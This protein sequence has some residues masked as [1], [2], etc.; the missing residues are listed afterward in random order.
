MLSVIPSQR[1]RARRPVMSLSVELQPTTTHSA[2]L[3]PPRWLVEGQWQAQM[4]SDERLPECVSM[5]APVRPLSGILCEVHGVCGIVVQPLMWSWWV[6]V[7]GPG[8]LCG[9]KYN[10]KYQGYFDTHFM[11]TTIS[12]APSTGNILSLPHEVHAGS[13]SLSTTT[14]T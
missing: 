9:T 3:L 2:L 8:C 6:D 5:R 12:V 1:C 11:S 14:M 4:H 10:V 13:S 7:L